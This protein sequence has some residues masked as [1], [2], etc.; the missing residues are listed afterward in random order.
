MNPIQFFVFAGEA[1]GDLHGSR[2]MASIKEIMPTVSFF[3]VGGPKMRAQGMECLF[4]MEDFEVMGFSS[5]LLALPKL[6]RQFL[7]L[8][9]SLLQ[10]KPQVVILIDYP[11]FNLRFAKS[12]RKH[13]YRGKIIHYICP[14][15]WAHGKG[16]IQQMAKTLDLL[17]V[18]YPFEVGCFKETQLPVHYVGNP[19]QETIRHY[20]YQVDKLSAFGVPQNEKQLIAI[21]PGSRSAEITRNLP[22]Q[23]AAAKLFLKDNPEAC[24]AISCAH[25][26]SQKLIESL[27][28]S[29]SFAKGRVVLVPKEYTY[30]LMRICRSAIAK[31]GTVTLE[32]ALHQKPTVVI[33]QLSFLN[34]M[35]AK[36]VLRLSLPY[37]CIVNILGEKEVFPELIE[38]TNTPEAICEHLQ[39]LNSDG[40][41]RVECEAN[42][43]KISSL[44][45]QD[46][47][48]MQAALAIQKL[49]HVQKGCKGLV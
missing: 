7:T 40:Q 37:Y 31:S 22:L 43:Q 18:I 41:A 28:N 48:S 8:R 4:G 5:V 39:Q 21:F 2:L 34:W 33:Y 26:K 45:Y 23:L 49:L 46:D 1:S 25:L 30:E 24:F 17:L 27:V 6:V 32:L 38:R 42:C 19:L 11:G 9:N 29:F 47:S 10:H 15:V 20:S 44:L 35:I 36:Y 16:R 12:L 3:G 14:S 13:G